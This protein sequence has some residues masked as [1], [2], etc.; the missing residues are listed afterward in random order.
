MIAGSRVEA[1]SL[2]RRLVDEDEEYFDAA[3]AKRLAELV[4]L[5]KPWLRRWFLGGSEAEIIGPWRAY[6][7]AG[8]DLVLEAAIDGGSALVPHDSMLARLRWVIR[9]NGGVP[10]LMVW[11]E[12]T[13][14][15]FYVGN[16]DAVWIARHVRRWKQPRYRNE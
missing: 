11:D 15:G 2:V 10:E 9:F 3:D 4:P 6:W 7:S 8:G 12:P 1:H 5:R 13:N 14:E 16:S